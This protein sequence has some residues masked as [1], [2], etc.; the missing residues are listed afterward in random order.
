M[1]GFVACDV[2]LDAWIDAAGIRPFIHKCPT[3]RQLRKV[4]TCLQI[5]VADHYTQEAFML[6]KQAGV[7]PATLT[8]LF[9]RE[10]AE[11]LTQLTQVLHMAAASAIDAEEF[12]TLFK[13]LSQIQGASNQLRETLFEFLVADIARKAMRPTSVRLNRKFKT[14]SGAAEADVIVI[15]DNVRVLMIECKDYNPYAQIPDALFKRWLQHNVPV[16]YRA[17]CAHPD[18]LNLPPHFEFWATGSLS[19]ESL[20]CSNRRRRPS[21]PAATQLI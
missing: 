2:L 16:C 5:F 19:K 11:G 4:G 20:I 21:N 6:A 9:G 10:V 18:W 3:L 15:H 14:N 17:A 7:I 12:D 13:K 8:T 1:N